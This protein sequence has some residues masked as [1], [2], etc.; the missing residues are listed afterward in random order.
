MCIWSIG[1]DT[2]RQPQ[3]AE[4]AVGTREYCETMKSL[5]AAVLTL[6]LLV[7]FMVA[8][9]VMTGGT[10]GV[11]ALKLCEG[12]YP[13]VVSFATKRRRT[14]GQHDQYEPQLP[15]GN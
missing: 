15:S 8:P 12:L 9:A 10:V 14:R 5:V 2:M 7:A 13:H 1:T 11:V 3:S 6:P 4:T